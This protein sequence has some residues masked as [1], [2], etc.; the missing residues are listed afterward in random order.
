MLASPLY[1]QRW[2]RHWLDLVRYTDD[3]EESW[4]YRD[5]V[6]D[7]FNADLPYDE[8]VRRQ[9]AG[10]L[11]PA[12][13][14]GAVNAD[15]IVATT[16]LSIGP[17]TGIDRKKRLTDIVDDQIDIVGRTF[18]GLTVACARC[19]DHKFDPITTTDYYGLAGIFFSSHVISDEAYLSHGTARLR[20]PL[21]GAAEV[22]RHQQH[23]GGV[24]KMEHRLQAAVDQQYSKFARTLLPQTSRYLLAAWDY[25]HRPAD[26]AKLSADEFATRENLHGF[27]LNQWL[28]YLKGPPFGPYQVL[29]V[30]ERDF[31]G[32]QGV[33]AWRV[34]AERPWWGVN[35][36][37][38]EVA[39]ETFCLPPRTLS[40]NPGTEGGAVGWKSP[41][42]GSVRITGKLTDADPLDG[43]G[44]V[45]AIDHV[46]DRSAARTFVRDSRSNGDNAGW[47][48]RPNPRA[49]DCG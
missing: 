18:L 40:I 1:G 19:H 46:R 23:Q 29:N 39:I 32:E 3:F 43:V 44:V 35:T 16:M 37:E 20:I 34:R 11:L 2:G 7:A 12:G 30:P 31:D 13:E 36:N 47:R 42:A 6:V 28:S 41:Y 8:F 14:P 26:Q 17:W 10:D 15:G 48:K 21:V 25:E 9:I 22:E 4:R 45:W 5:W 24:Q 27:A 38:R 33:M 49:A